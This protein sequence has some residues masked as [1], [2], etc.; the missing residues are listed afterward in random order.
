MPHIYRLFD[1]S[2]SGYQYQRRKYRLCAKV[3]IHFAAVE[4]CL[5]RGQYI[6]VSEIHAFRCTYAHIVF[7]IFVNLYIIHLSMINDVRFDD[8]DIFVTLAHV[9]HE[10][11]SK[12]LITTTANI[13]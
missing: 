13:S 10:S 11:T 1:G 8:S 3:I 5:I 12:Q 6:F 2:S 7:N 9:N 4:E